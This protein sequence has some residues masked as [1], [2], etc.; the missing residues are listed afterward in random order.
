M[1]SSTSQAVCTTQD[2]SATFLFAYAADFDPT[3]YGL[4]SR[5]IGSYVTA[6]LPTGQTLANVLTDLT[7]E[8]DIKYTNVA[9]DFTTNCVTDQ[10]DATLARSE[11]QASTA[12]QTIQQFLKNAN[13]TM[14]L[15]GSI[16]ILLVNRLPKNDDDLISG[17][18]DQLTNLNVK[19]FPIITIR[20][21]VEHS[22]IAS[23]SGAVFNRIAAQTNGHYIVANDTIGVDVNSDFNKIIA[24]FMKTSYNQNLLFVRN[25]GSNRFLSLG[26]SIGTL[27]IPKSPTESATV[28]VTI[29]VSLSAVDT[30]VPQLPRRLLLAI[31]GNSKFNQTKTVQ[32]DFLNP[33]NV[34]S[35]ANSNYYT[36]T[37]NLDAGIENNLILLY[38][39]GPDQND[40]L[41]RMWTPNA[42]HRSASYVN[43]KS[44]P[45]TPVNKITESTGAALKFTLENQCSSDK[46]A[47]LLITDCNGE[48]SA[49]YDSDQIFNWKDNSTFYQFVPFF[50]DNQPTP[51]TCISG[52]ESKYDAQFV[53]ND[54]SVTQS[55][56]C[57]P[58]N[59]PTDNCKLKDS[60]GNYQ[61]S[62]T[63]PFMRGPEGSLTDC[64]GHGHL[65]YDE[66]T[67]LFSCIC[68]PGFSGPSCEIVTC[69]NQNT[70]PL[71]KDNAYHT[72]TV[73]VGLEKT[74]G[75][76]VFDDAK[77]LFGLPGLNGTVDL[78]EVWKYQ[79]LTICADGVFDM[80]YSGS[81]LGE[82]Q[83]LF[84]SPNYELLARTC[85]TPPSPGVN[86]LTTIYKEAVK[87]IGRNVKGI[88]VYFSEV[89]S[90]INVT[91]DEFI[92]ASQPYQQQFFVYAVDET[93]MPILPNGERIAKAAMTT[94][95]FLIQSYITDDV[96]GHL[97]TQ[98]IPDFLQS[99]TSIAWYSSDQV[100]DFTYFTQN[101]I[102]AY[103]ITWNVGDNFKI[104]NGVPFRNCQ[105][106]G[107]ENVECKIQGPQT[108]KGNIDRGAF[109]VAV[110][111]LDDPLI[112]K[113]QIISDLDRDS[114]NAVST[115]SSDTRT[116][117]TFNI[118]EEYDIVANSGDGG[119]TRNAQRNGCTFDWT[120]YSV[121]ATQKYTPGLNIAK[122][123]LQDASSNTYTRFFPFGTSSAPVCQNG[124]TPIQSDGS[125]LCPSGFQGSDCSL[126]NC[127]QSSTSNAWSDV[128]V[129]NEIDDATCARQFTSIF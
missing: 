17:E 47:T 36:T 77:V 98:F 116:M 8:M 5:T 112:P 46:T 83:R 14:R 9:N 69:T 106:A 29:T 13:A 56:Q 22:A 81:D 129:C 6:N 48:V 59:G 60:N 105:I 93:S 80:I 31:L 126:V 109:Y 15:E 92:A 62:G 128:C 118:P 37:V 3:T 115:S 108:V 32:I 120:A 123:T 10:P 12:L 102:F 125:C 54:F 97:D 99:S 79:L 73:V 86:D 55:F 78:P 42:I 53:S 75:F 127:S 2:N 122:I 34:T 72:Y 39:A 104:N 66:P 25:I 41:I 84:T 50:C 43:A 107:N 117:L 20:N 67:K 63:S 45:L 88:I 76:L 64:S 68:D 26:S 30:N 82:F 18:Y 11:V 95:G 7:T 85:N 21:L 89:S 19:I 27:R 71:A 44:E 101:N 94:G 96:K 65:E 113:V 40:V 57:R 51:T 58:G 52:A 49:K 90:M 124:G 74:N 121:F 114:S 70:D 110:Y 33:E 23:R 35:F 24:N 28:P 100:D 16:I 119:V 61:C 1:P 87:G 38:D 4:V 103:V 91:L 111:L